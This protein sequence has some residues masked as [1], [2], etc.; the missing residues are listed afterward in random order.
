MNNL[1]RFEPLR[2][3]MT[4]RQFMDRAMDEFLGRPL[5]S[6]NFLA[7]PPVDAYQTE[8]EV[9]VKV[10]LPGARP[11]DISISVTGD[12]LTI[13]GEINEESQHERGEY[14]LRERRFGN[15]TRALALPTAVVSDKAD[16]S[17]KD[18]ILTLT[19]PK[20]DEVKP[21]QISVKAK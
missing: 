2:E 11:E 21:R 10:V 19:L 7:A 14:L 5:N 16:A 15:F 9:V 12:V 17:Y 6:Y 18:G 20:A 8:D 13:K 3:M 4:M 1:I